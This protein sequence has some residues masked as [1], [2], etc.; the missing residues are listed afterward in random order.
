[1]RDGVKVNKE[2]VKHIRNGIPPSV[3]GTV[4]QALARSKD[5]QLVKKYMELLNQPSPFEKLIQRD[6]IPGQENLYHV[7]KA[8]STYDQQVGYCQALNHIVN[9]LLSNV[10]CFFFLL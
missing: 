2:L 9:P 4:W 10:S 1:M 3:R 8:Y 6:L 5:D 7:V